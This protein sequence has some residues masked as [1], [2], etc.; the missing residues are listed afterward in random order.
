MSEQQVKKLFQGITDIDDD[1]IE[2]AQTSPPV[3][4]IPVWRRWGAIAACL[5]LVALV[6]TLAWRSAEPP[7]APDAQGGPVLGMD[8]SDTGDE[9]DGA[10]GCATLPGGITPMLRVDD[11][12][13][14][15]TG[16]SVRH[17]LDPGGSFYSSGD[18]VTYLPEGYQPCGDISGVTQET[19]TEDL[20]L[21]AGFEASGTVFVSEDRPAV[22]YVLMTT[23]WFEDSYVRFT[24]DALGK[25]ELLSWQGRTYRLSIDF[26]VCKPL[27]ELPEGCEL[28]GNLHFVGNDSI[29]TGDLETN[30]MSDVHG[31]PFEGR[32]V[33]AIPGGNST[34]YVYEHHYW[35]EGDYPT[36]R[37]CH[38]W[39]P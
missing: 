2:E 26:D 16:L 36:W 25:N 5:C 9:I 33:Y 34:L 6:G 39:E 7:N 29:P 20:Q 35:R 27:E 15:W 3:K 30:N 37:E 18:G 19:P 31:K 24:S 4:R 38:L 28:I 17:F 23:D 14:Q 1:I 10:A 13:Y 11:T 32:E 12:L 8:E 21:Q 22:I